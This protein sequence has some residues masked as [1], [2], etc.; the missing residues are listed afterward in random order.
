MDAAML[1][2]LPLVPL[3]VVFLM[4]LVDPITSEPSF[5]AWFFPFL[6]LL[7]L[8]FSLDQRSSNRQQILTIPEHSQGLN[9]KDIVALAGAH[10]LGRCHRNRSGYDGPWTN[11]PTAFSNDYFVQLFERKW[12]PRQWDGP[13]QYEDETK[14]LMMLPADLAFAQDP[15]FEGWARK[16]ASDE[17]LFFDAFSQAFSKLL[18]LGVPFPQ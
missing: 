18:E 12:T 13:L 6:L 7:L 9:D 2:L 11:S 10:A 4:P 14:T 17:D 16:F 3:M 1:L 8:L 15:I 5:I